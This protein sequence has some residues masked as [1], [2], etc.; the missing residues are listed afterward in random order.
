MVMEFGAVAYG[1]TSS[2]APAKACL[3]PENTATMSSDY[4]TIFAFLFWFAK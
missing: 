4:S 1:W 3:T 2:V